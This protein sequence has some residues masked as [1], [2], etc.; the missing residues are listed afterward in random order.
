MRIFSVSE[1]KQRVLHLIL[2]LLSIGYAML[3]VAARL[4]SGY[5]YGTSQ[6]GPLTGSVATQLIGISQ[7]IDAGF[8]LY[9]LGL[10]VCCALICLLLPLPCR[11]YVRYTAFFLFLPFPLLWW[12]DQFSPILRE[13]GGV[14]VR[15]G[16]VLGDS[17]FWTCW[18]VG[19]VALLAVECMK[20]WKAKR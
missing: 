6:K 13:R 4:I 8:Q 7:G 2:F 19:F 3:L 16:M 18:T 5:L 9:A 1:K 11:M 17:R 15:P 12:M 14:F 20:R 10:V